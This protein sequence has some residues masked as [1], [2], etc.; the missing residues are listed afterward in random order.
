MSPPQNQIIWPNLQSAG[1]A[2]DWSNI[3]T[4]RKCCKAA[5][6]PLQP[7]ER[8]RTG[9]AYRK[10]PNLGQVQHQH[11]SHVSEPGGKDPAGC[12]AGGSVWGELVSPTCPSAT[13]EQ[14][15]VQ[16]WDSQ[17]KLSLQQ[18]HLAEAGEHR[19]PHAGL[20]Q[21]WWQNIQTSTETKTRLRLC[22]K[23]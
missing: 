22:K 1:Q 10:V 5:A 17:S 13:L 11:V 23:K 16:G 18:G 2:G 12:T 19:L 14:P 4:T 15:L 6:G 20:Q 8:V 7:A 9:L 21:L 3:Y